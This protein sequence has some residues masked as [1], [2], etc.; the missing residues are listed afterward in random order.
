MQIQ[1]SIAHN[2]L[3]GVKNF[4]TEPK[5]RYQE[6]KGSWI[7]ST[8]MSNQNNLNFFKQKCYLPIGAEIE[9]LV[10]TAVKQNSYFVIYD[11][12]WADCAILL[13]WEDFSEDYFHERSV[14]PR[15]NYRLPKIGS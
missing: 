7:L 10:Y 13:Q 8:W 11:Q 4:G 12:Y 6:G 9:C 2:W 3:G 1:R 14:E 15:G 5:L